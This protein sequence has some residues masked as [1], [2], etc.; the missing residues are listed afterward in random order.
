MKLTEPS[1]RQSG[2]A[3]NDAAKSAPYTVPVPLLLSVPKIDGGT[4]TRRWYSL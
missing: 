1:R 4:D 3:W 2:V